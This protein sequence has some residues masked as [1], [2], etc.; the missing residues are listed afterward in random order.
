MDYLISVKVKVKVKIKYRTKSIDFVEFN[1][2]LEKE[3]IVER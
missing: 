2:F 3:K 1:S